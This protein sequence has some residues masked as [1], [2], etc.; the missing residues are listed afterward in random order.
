MDLSWVGRA[1]LFLLLVLLPVLALVQPPPGFEPPPRRSLYLSAS[2]LLW[3]LTVVTVLV[4]A[5][6]GIGPYHIALTDGRP[7]AVLG[8]SA[9]ATVA[10]LLA[11]GLATLAGRRLRLRESPWVAH[12]MPRD[13]GDRWAF[14]A[15]AMT[16]GV[17][18]ELMYRGF[19]L[20]ALS[21]ALGDRPW[22]AAAL[23][24]V[25]FGILH[26]YQRLIGVIRATLMGFLLAV[27]AVAGGTL[28]ASMIAHTA[29]DLVLSFSAR[30]LLP[31]LESEGKPATEGAG[32][33]GD[34][35]PEG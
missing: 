11:A 19:A 24:A 28:L 14:V 9:A 20:W 7:V 15:V 22:H 2:A 6:E 27:P 34:A 8:W 21:A 5:W 16:A 3:A 4:L 13:R 12:L 33:G 17:T 26:A 18:E 35:A 30:T 23:V 31:E 1:H 10:A 25:A 29:V 32:P